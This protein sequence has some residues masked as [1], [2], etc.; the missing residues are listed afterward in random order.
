MAGVLQEK[1]RNVTLADIAREWVK[2]Q[3]KNGNRAKKFFGVTNGRLNTY[4]FPEFGDRPIN[5][6]TPLDLLRLVQRK[7]VTSAWLTRRG[8]STR[9]V[10]R[11][12]VMPYFSA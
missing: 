6:I 3:E 4:V 9:C 2:Q 7:Y 11:F 8:A 5:E 1:K 10:D 12:F